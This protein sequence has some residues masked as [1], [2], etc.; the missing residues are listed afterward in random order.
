MAP[1]KYE[2]FERKLGRLARKI[3][4][5]KLPRDVKESLVLIISHSEN[6]VWNEGKTHLYKILFLLQKWANFP[7]GTHI[8]DNFG[9]VDVETRESLKN[10]V[11][12]KIIRPVTLNPYKKTF[13]LTQR[14][15]N[16]FRGNFGE[17]NQEMRDFVQYATTG[18]GRQTEDALKIVIDICYAEITG[19]KTKAPTH[20]ISWKLFLESS[21]V[22]T[23][24][25]HNLLRYFHKEFKHEYSRPFKSNYKITQGELK[26]IKYVESKTTLEQEFRL[27]NPHKHLV[28]EDFK[29]FNSYIPIYLEGMNS[30]ISIFQR[31]PTKKDI[32]SICL[33]TE[34]HRAKVKEIQ[35]K[36]K[37]LKREMDHDPLKDNYQRISSLE[38][39]KT[40]HTELSKLSP[41]VI[42]QAF[43]IMEKK[44]LVEVKDGKYY[45]P[46][47]K[48]I[49]GKTPTDA[50]KI[51]N[52]FE[53]IDS[54]YYLS[55]MESDTFQERFPILN[56]IKI[57]STYY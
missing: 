48:Y 49:A 39:E 54:E 9:P 16:Y 2:E 34:F 32:A 38:S 17:L 14:G 56:G 12:F 21:I 36:I 22:H 33:R 50:G 41:T 27:E 15:R 5:E 37:N 42:S 29:T 20:R 53:L 13:K 10:L 40:K 35:N 18:M 19:Q 46:A 52:S 25:A 24:L 43:R 7:Y 8:I 11:K 6:E 51:E 45:L 1:F 23:T 4:L 3:S 30:M 47:R 26:D 31:A 28:P 55:I 57:P 44:E